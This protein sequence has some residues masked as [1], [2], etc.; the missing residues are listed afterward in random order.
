M[1]VACNASVQLQAQI[2]EQ[3]ETEEQAEGTVAHSVAMMAAGGG[4]PHK[5]GD[6]IEYNGRK[7]AVD[8]DMV[9]GARV[10]AEALGGP[11]GNLR[12]EDAV[13]CS[14]IHPTAC[15]GTPDAW[16]YIREGTGPLGKP[17]LRIGDYKYGHRFVEVFENFQL[18]AY[19]VGVV[20]RLNLE[21]LGDDLILELI[22]VQPRAY[23]KEGPVRKWR[24]TVGE[25]RPLVERAAAAATA[26]L[27]VDPKATTGEHC[28]DCRARHICVTLRHAVANI[29]DYS[30]T[31]ELAPLDAIAM[32]HE[33][34]ILEDAADRL[35]ARRTGI[36]VQVEAALRAGQRVPGYVLEPGR[37]NMAWMV[38]APIA[39]L[40]AMGDLLGVD[41][42]KPLAVCT[43]TQ[44]IDSGI[45]KEIVSQ[46]AHRPPGALKLKAESITTA[47]KAFST[48][49][50][51][52]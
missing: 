36:A 5:V 15:Y 2:P 49:V 47:R 25:V 29:V 16:R 39:E 40:A 1:T 13:Q 10:Y 12:L 32:G 41:I 38:D 33:L 21:S 4:L 45:D 52:T 42:R 34:R 37:A 19:A 3:P 7:W 18:V 8:L 23:H 30:G 26:A 24:T 27:A 22:L 48:G 43:P 35:A 44:A 20:E 31:A 46:F 9:N 11:H 14:R 17:V 50:S 28:I 6:V 51:S